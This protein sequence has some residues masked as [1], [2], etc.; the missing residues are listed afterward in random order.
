VAPY[1]VRGRTSCTGVE[2]Y[3]D[4][5]AAELEVHDPRYPV[6]TTIF[7]RTAMIDL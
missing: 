4:R 2:A 7:C 1:R 5:L 6:L 3:P